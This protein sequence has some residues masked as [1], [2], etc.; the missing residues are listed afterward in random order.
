MRVASIYLSFQALRFSRRI[1]DPNNPQKHKIEN[2]FK[3][4]S[5]KTTGTCDWLLCT[6]PKRCTRRIPGNVTRTT[7]KINQR[8]THIRSL[9]PKVKSVTSKEKEEVARFQA[10]IQPPNQVRAMNGSKKLHF[11]KNNEC[12]FCH[13]K[14]HF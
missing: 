1:F 12:Y 11:W 3:P 10:Q 9:P 8:I 14:S 7:L 5:L 6:S 2:P 13:F 4:K